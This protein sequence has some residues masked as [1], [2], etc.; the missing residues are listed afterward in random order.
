V[1]R[2]AR[3]ACR[4][5]LV[6]S[7]DRPIRFELE[8]TGATYAGRSRGVLAECNGTP[9]PGTIDVR[10]TVTAADRIGSVWRATKIRGK[11]TLSVPQSFIGKVRCPPGSY[12]DALS[13]YLPD[14]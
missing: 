1:P 8:R 14:A 6:F 5:G 12:S 4:V 7:L 3:G 13:G 10:V 11:L 2:C 9:V